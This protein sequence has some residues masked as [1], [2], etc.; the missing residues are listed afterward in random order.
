VPN[1][2]FVKTE[3]VKLTLVETPSDIC[4]LQV[5]SN[6]LAQ[7]RSMNIIVETFLSKYRVAQKQTDIWF[8]IQVCNNDLK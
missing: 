8:P 3:L 2:H 1:S 6:F 4:E 5:N 7:A